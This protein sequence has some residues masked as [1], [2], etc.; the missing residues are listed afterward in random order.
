MSGKTARAVAC[1]KA[2][3]QFGGE[4]RAGVETFAFAFAFSFAFAFAFAREIWARRYLVNREARPTLLRSPRVDST[5]WMGLDWMNI[6]GSTTSVALIYAMSLR[7]FP[8]SWNDL[9]VSSRHRSFSSLDH[10]SAASLSLAL[11]LARLSSR[12]APPH[13]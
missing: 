13:L 7:S 6:S 4:R 11:T 9:L 12:P 2:A 10:P 1:N 3:F 5:G 8:D